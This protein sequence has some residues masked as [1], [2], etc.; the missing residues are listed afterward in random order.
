MNI[1]VIE[2]VT[3]RVLFEKLQAEIFDIISSD[4]FITQGIIKY[5]KWCFLC[6]YSM[7]AIKSTLLLLCTLDA[8][9]STNAFSIMM[10]VQRNLQLESKGLSHKKVERT[11]T[12]QWYY[13]SA[14]Y[15]WAEMDRPYRSWCN[16]W[17]VTCCGIWMITMPPSSKV[18]ATFQKFD[19]YNVPEA[20]NFKTQ[21]TFCRE[22]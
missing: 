21:K 22:S 1:E 15:I 17:Y 12:V 4:K 11:K 9:K 13:W 7:H 20:L 14:R 6:S 19:G 10:Q 18:P 8:I 16:F 2:D 5:S 3:L